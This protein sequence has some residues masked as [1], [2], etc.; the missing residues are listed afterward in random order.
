MLV[1]ASYVVNARIVYIIYVYESE[2]R[3]PEDTV[4][5]RSYSTITAG[6]LSQYALAIHYWL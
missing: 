3:R 4:L 1:L 6:W 5:T 2:V